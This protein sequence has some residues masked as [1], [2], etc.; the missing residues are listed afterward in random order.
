MLNTAPNNSPDHQYLWS[1]QSNSAPAVLR[2]GPF[3]QQLTWDGFD[4][5]QNSFFNTFA[6]SVI[7]QA[8]IME[9]VFIVKATKSVNNVAPG[10]FDMAGLDNTR[11]CVENTCY[12]VIKSQLISNLGPW[13]HWDK[14][15]GI[16]KLGEYN[17]NLT[18]IAQAA[19]WFQSK[20][21]AYLKIPT[22]ESTQGSIQDGDTP[23]YNMWVNLPVVDYD[24]APG[25]SDM[26]I[27]GDSKSALVR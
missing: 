27:Y 6:G 18:A 22:V 26:Q 1:S 4:F 15:R 8:W 9:E 17:T 10:D 25:I 19:D 14:V 24:N 7:N 2:N 20:F 3:A 16:D 5:I 11:A 12:F 23:P 13:G 21:G